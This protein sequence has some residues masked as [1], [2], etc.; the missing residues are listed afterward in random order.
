MSA[1]PAKKQRRTNRTRAR[2]LDAAALVFCE[3]GY[4]GASLGAITAR[5]ELGTGTL[6][7]YFRDKRSVYEAMVRREGLALR[8]RW[9][10]ARAARLPARADVG[11]EVRLLCEVVLA[12]WSEAKPE[13][14]RLVLLDGPPVETWLVED[15]GRVISPVLAE[16][17]TDADL[18]AQL[19]IGALLA[20][21]RFRLMQPRQISNERLT[22]MVAAFC[23]GGIA[24][25]P[26]R[27]TTKRRGKR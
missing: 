18:L 3:Q 21:Q 9:L 6:Y 24:A 13:L 27:L 26:R 10:E 19:V 20:C 12:S 14:T 5:A 1:E 23:A 8:E 2:L 22:D 16:H 17:I 15:V 4:D 25:E 11:A 7:L